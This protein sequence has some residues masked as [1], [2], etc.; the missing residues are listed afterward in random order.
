MVGDMS[1][2]MTASMSR[3]MVGR[4]FTGVNR[5]VVVSGNVVINRNIAFNRFHRFHG[6]HRNAFFF[7]VGF[8]CTWW[9]N[10]CCL[11]SPLGLAVGLR[12]SVLRL[13]VLGLLS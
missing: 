6:F 9:G 4:A 5:N 13:P 12:I 8:T 11:G 2:P 7:G 1:R 3:P 10:S